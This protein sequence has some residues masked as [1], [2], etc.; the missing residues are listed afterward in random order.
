MKLYQLTHTF[1]VYRITH[2]VTA[3]VLTHASLRLA[4]IVALGIT[5]FIASDLVVNH[6]E[7]EA[8]SQS[9]LREC[10]AVLNGDVKMLDGDTGEVAKVTWSK[11]NLIGGV[12]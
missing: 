7:Y 2:S 1:E 9:D 12:Q 6:L 11:V 4:A 10:V 3:Q 5:V 8:K